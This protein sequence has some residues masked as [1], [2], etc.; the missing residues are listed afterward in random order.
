[1]PVMPQAEAL[2]KLQ[3][4][5]LRILRNNRRL[6]EIAA[7][8]ENNETVQAAQNAVNEAEERLKPLHRRQRELEQEIQSNNQKSKT[9][10]DRLYSGNVK[11]PKELQ[12]LQNEIAA[13]KNRNE[14]LEELLL[15]QMMTVELAETELEEKEDE[16]AKVKAA[17]EADHQDL[18]AEKQQIE[19]DN[20]AEITQRKAAL[21]P[22]NDDSLKRYEQ[23]KPRKANQPIAALNGDSCSVCGMQQTMTII[24]DVGS[25]KDF[26]SC[27]NCG[28]ILANVSV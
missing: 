24:Q 27:A 11:N 4:I 26:V 3:K 12:D 7:A 23:M 21:Q 5:D 10:E 28:R 25:G 6:A 20:A 15:E 22:I 13:L 2:Y 16:L 19:A 1:M 8:L 18:L 9:S 14:E 17:W